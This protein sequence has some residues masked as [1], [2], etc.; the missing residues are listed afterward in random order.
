[1]KLLFNLYDSPGYQSDM[2]E[3]YTEVT[4]EA[5]LLGKVNGS[6]REERTVRE[7]FEV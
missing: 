7:T 4:V 3:Y 6:D 2:P 1:M 5:S